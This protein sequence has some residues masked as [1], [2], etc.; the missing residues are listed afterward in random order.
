MIHG[1]TSHPAFNNHFKVHLTSKRTYQ[2]PGTLLSTTLSTNF[3]IRQLTLDGAQNIQSGTSISWSFSTD[4]GTSWTPIT[5]NGEQENITGTARQVVLKAD[6]T[7]SGTVTP[8]I[9][10]Y[11]FTVLGPTAGG[12]PGGEVDARFTGKEVDETELARAF[13]VIAA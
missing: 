9:E 11:A 7:G 3:D 5:I 10:D 8:V 2:T 6:L 12:T 4:G 13:S 1:Q